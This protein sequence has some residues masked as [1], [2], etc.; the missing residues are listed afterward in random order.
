MCTG[1]HIHKKRLK[2]VIRMGMEKTRRERINDFLEGGQK[3]MF[4]V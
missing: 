4:Y 3:K 1:I 2:E